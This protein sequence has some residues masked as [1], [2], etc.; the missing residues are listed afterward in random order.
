MKLFLTTLIIGLT[1]SEYALAVDRVGYPVKCIF[2]VGSGSASAPCIQFDKRRRFSVNGVCVYSVNSHLWMLGNWIYEA[3]RT[4]PSGFQNKFVKTKSCNGG[5]EYAQDSDEATVKGPKQWDQDIYLGVDNKSMPPKGLLTYDASLVPLTC[6]TD[7]ARSTGVSRNVVP[8]THNPFTPNYC[9]LRN[10]DTNPD[11]KKNPTKIATGPGYWWVIYPYGKYTSTKSKFSEFIGYKPGEGYKKFENGNVII[12]GV[13]TTTKLTS[14]SDDLFVKN[15]GTF[16]YYYEDTFT[17][18]LGGVTL[19]NDKTKETIRINNEA[20]Q[21]SKVAD[22]ALDDI[23]DVN[24]LLKTK[25][26]TL[27]ITYQAALESLNTAIK[28][29][30]DAEQKLMDAHNNVIAP[31]TTNKEVTAKNAA[32]AALTNSLAAFALTNA[33]GTVNSTSALAKYNAAHA[34][35]ELEYD[36]YLGGDDASSLGQEKDETVNCPNGFSHLVNIPTADN[37]TM[38]ADE[39]N[40]LNAGNTLSAGTS[41]IPTIAASVA[42]PAYLEQPI[43]RVH[44]NDQLYRTFKGIRDRRYDREE[45]AL[46]A[47]IASP[48]LLSNMPSNPGSLLTEAYLKKI[49]EEKRAA[50]ELLQTPE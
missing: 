23:Q 28:T 13:S 44:N 1:A 19:A 47:V 33:N 2:T 14:L 9:E 45:D 38:T 42:V 48:A 49:A 16:R 41:A 50:L 8:C 3:S 46:G 20:V 6:Y 30:C 22:K 15:G 36:K 31:P 43:N 29:R 10:S 18:C 5:I 7:Q 27:Y 35:L 17:V 39:I 37:R 12:N 40:D 32:I 26:T 11:H 21:A 4:S 25:I 34:A 24:K